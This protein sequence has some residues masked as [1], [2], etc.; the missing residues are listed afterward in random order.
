MMARRDSLSWWVVVAAELG[1]R[2]ISSVVGVG[3]SLGCHLDMAMPSRLDMGYRCLDR[4]PGR[5]GLA[6]GMDGPLE[7]GPRL[8]GGWGG[9]ELCESGLGEAVARGGG[10][11]GMARRGRA[12]LELS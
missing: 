8:V 5:T 1:R 11:C 7:T 2:V 6:P 9:D 12:G 4:S 10:E 3:E